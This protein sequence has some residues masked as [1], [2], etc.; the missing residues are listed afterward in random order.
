MI[1]Q[2]SLKPCYLWDFPFEELDS[3]QLRIISTTR[4][5]TSPETSEAS[6]PSHSEEES[7]DS[8]SSDEED[9]AASWT[10][11]ICELAFDHP[12]TQRL[13]FQ[14]QQHQLKISSGFSLSILSPSTLPFFFFFLF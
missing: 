2:S 12:T 4:K 14:S 1:T 10:C 6:S 13:H 3:N 5:L 11:R 7:C 9:E 8:L